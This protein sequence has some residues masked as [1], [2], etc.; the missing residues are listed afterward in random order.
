LYDIVKIDIEELAIRG[1]ENAELSGRNEVNLIDLL[2]SLLDQNITKQNVSDYIKQTKIKYRFAKRAFI[3]KIFDSE[4]KERES[5]IRKISINNTME[6]NAIPENI[7]NAIPKPL[8]IFPRDFALKET[9]LKLELNE[10]A[11][12]VKAMMK[13]M[14]KKSLED[15]ISSNTYYDLSKKHSRRKTSIDI[16]NIYTDIVKTE[17]INLGKKF[18]PMSKFDKEFAQLKKEENFPL[19]I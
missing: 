1:K 15:I 11:K 6:T 16:N 13:T 7:V 14:E 10:E 12:K 18:R 5:L 2:F 4:E 17:N 3:E 19:C 8:R 9:E